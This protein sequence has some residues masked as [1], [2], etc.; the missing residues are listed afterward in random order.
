[1]CFFLEHYYI[2]WWCSKVAL[3]RMCVCVNQNTLCCEGKE[4]VSTWGLGMGL[5]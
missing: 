5:G 1:M 4:Y 2:L 3:C